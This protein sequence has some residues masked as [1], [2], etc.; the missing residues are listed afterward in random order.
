[1]MKNKVAYTVLAL[2]CVVAGAYAWHAL[3]TRRPGC[4]GGFPQVCTRCDHF[5]T[6]SE[7]E[8]Y[9]HPKSP[10][11]E[12]FKCPKCNQFGGRTAVKCGTCGKWVVMQETRGAATC[13][14][15][16]PPAK[17]GPAR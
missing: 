6:L 1:M 3:L 9:S 4:P 10:Q 7:D 15:C 11:G 12:G 13:P 5:F 2:V 8:L 16:Q 17:S 14:K